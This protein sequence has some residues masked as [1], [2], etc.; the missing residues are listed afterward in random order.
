MA[1]ADRPS[2]VIPLHPARP[3]L[4]ASTLTAAHFG[5][6]ASLTQL[7]PGHIRY[8]ADRFDLMARRDH[9]KDVLAAVTVYVKAVI[10]DTQDVA[11]GAIDDNSGYLIDA[12]GDIMGAFDRRIDA[13]EGW[14]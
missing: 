4:P 7:R 8:R 13:N 6:V 10:A 9:V 5:L 1:Q 3:A 11:E 12:A 2:N 14:E